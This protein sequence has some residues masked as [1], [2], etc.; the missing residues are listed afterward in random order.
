MGGVWTRLKLAVTAFFTILF[1]HRLPAALER[2]GPAVP[3]AAAS[4]PT[5]GDQSDRAIQMLAL[6]QRAAACVVLLPQP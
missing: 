6:L 2:P 3:P 4:P 5:A 1:Q